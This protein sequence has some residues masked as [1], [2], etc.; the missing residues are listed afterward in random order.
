LYIV[1]NALKAAKN[2]ALEDVRRYQ[3][4]IKELS[5]E[6]ESKKDLEFSAS[7]LKSKLETTAAK[8]QTLYAAFS[9]L[10]K[11]MEMSLQE[12]EAQISKKITFFSFRLHRNSEQISIVQK[13]FNIIRSQHEHDRR[14][15]K[16]IR[17]GEQAGFQR[18][19][20]CSQASIEELLCKRVQLE[21]RITE[22]SQ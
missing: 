10:P 11:A 13:A 3:T 2:Q 20:D 15:F 4:R 12:F 7:A 14:E 6:L 8:F 5:S 18:I 21:Q 1:N 9:S 16:R 19:M 22:I 17:K